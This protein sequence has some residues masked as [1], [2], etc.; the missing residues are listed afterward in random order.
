MEV[1][2]SLYHIAPWI[3]K[4]FVDCKTICICLAISKFEGNYILKC[5]Q[6]P[7][8]YSLCFP[9]SSQNMKSDVFKGNCKITERGGRIC[10][11]HSFYGP[12]FCLD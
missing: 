11:L 4:V 3:L 10:V 8:T 5:S 12:S 9:L 2:I 6:L 7:P 1:V